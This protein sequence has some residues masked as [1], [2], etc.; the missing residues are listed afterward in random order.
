MLLMAAGSLTPHQ[1]GEGNV[2]HPRTWG[3]LVP[4]AQPCVM[5]L[6]PSNQVP[7][8][9]NIGPIKDVHESD[10]TLTLPRLGQQNNKVDG[11]LGRPV[12][13]KFAR[14]VKV[15]DGLNSVITEIPQHL[16]CPAISPWSL[17]R[18]FP[19][20]SKRL[21]QRNGLQLLRLR[22]G[23]ILKCGKRLG[24]EVTS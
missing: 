3:S 15:K 14:P 1:P 9:S 17:A 20:I 12:G 5:K 11:K 7:T 21:L 6:P 18:K 13:P 16:G 23:L 2:Q 8:E 19:E 22:N 10:R 24:S 4:C